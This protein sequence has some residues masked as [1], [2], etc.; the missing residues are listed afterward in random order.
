MLGVTEGRSLNRKEIENLSKEEQRDWK[1]GEELT[2][3][4]MDTHKTKT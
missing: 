1:L 3:T 4:C 2:R